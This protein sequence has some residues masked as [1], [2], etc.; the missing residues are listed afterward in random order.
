MSVMRT[1]APLQL[2]Y[3]LGYAN[4]MMQSRVSIDAECPK[5]KERL[6]DGL[7]AVVKALYRAY[8]AST[9]KGV[10][11]SFWIENSTLRWDALNSYGGQDRPGQVNWKAFEDLPRW[12]EA[13]YLPYAQVVAALPELITRLEIIEIEDAGLKQCKTDDETKTRVDNVS[14]LIRETMRNDG[15]I[16]HGGGLRITIHHRNSKEVVNG[17][18]ALERH[19][20]ASSD[21]TEN[22]LLGRRSKTGGLGQDN[23]DENMERTQILSRLALCWEPT[24][25]LWAGALGI[26]PS[27]YTLTWDTTVKG[28]AEVAKTELVTAQ[29]ASLNIASGVVKAEAYTNRYLGGETP[30]VFPEID[31]EDPYPAPP[32]VPGTPG[33]PEPT[34]PALTKTPPDAP[35]PVR[36]T[37]TRSL[38]SGVP[39]NQEGG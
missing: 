23:T 10:A 24:I 3:C 11:V 20:L 9:I 27:D 25:E 16:I 30:G 35:S 19:M 2:K 4:R 29:A 22:A 8:C 38:A 14:R 31:P 39:Q 13:A 21:Y 33:V 32:E 37:S 28:A 26:K 17:L 6:T 36:Q 18:A 12:N 5:V 1:L 7:P 34:R 15:F